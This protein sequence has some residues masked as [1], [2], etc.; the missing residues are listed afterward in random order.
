MFLQ[1]RRRT[2]I[3]SVS[4]APTLNCSFLIPGE[5]KRGTAGWPCPNFIFPVYN[6]Y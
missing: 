2:D 4:L 6:C 1:A 5:R 3:G